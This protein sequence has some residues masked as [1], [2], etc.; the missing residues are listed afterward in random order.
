MDVNQENGVETLQN[1]QNEHIIETNRDALEVSGDKLGNFQSSAFVIDK[2][3][4]NTDNSNIKTASSYP[5]SPSFKNKF[6]M[7]SFTVPKKN[8]F[9]GPESLKVFM[10]SEYFLSL[11]LLKQCNRFHATILTL[12]FD[13][14]CLC[15]YI[16]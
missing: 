16:L 15:F 1:I 11:M 8:K 3:D 10:S 9:V 13:M 6:S 12:F 2:E 5:S 14:I 7:L 4:E